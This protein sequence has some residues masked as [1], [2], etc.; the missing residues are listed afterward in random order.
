[1]A[2]S[3]KALTPGRRRATLK[4]V[5]E[6]AGVS[7]SAVSRTFTQGA[8]VAPET[9]VKFY[10]N[11][12]TWSRGV[13]GVGYHARASYIDGLNAMVYLWARMGFVVGRPGPTDAGKPAAIPARIFVEVDRDTVDL[14]A[15]APP[16]SEG[17]QR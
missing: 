4:E 10:E 15:K 5:A 7:T 8:S 14:A 2:K 17:L 6:L 3:K 1:M 11:R 9:R 16:P 12:L 13:A